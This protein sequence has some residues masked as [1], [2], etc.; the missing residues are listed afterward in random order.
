MKAKTQ[1]YFLTTPYDSYEV[2][3][4]FGTYHNGR[5]QIELL[6]AQD[7]EPIMVATVNIK[8]ALLHGNE[9]IIKNYSENEGVLNFLIKNKIV[10]H[11]KYWLAS[12][13]VSCPVVDLLIKPA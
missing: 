7:H 13:W 2:Y 4:N 9:I 8:D 6:D 5:T 11:P 10:S 12:E 3:L 1:S